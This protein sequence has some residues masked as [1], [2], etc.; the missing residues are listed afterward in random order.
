[1]P[2]TDNCEDEH[3]KSKLLHGV[4]K[5][6][7]KSQFVV[8]NGSSAAHDEVQPLTALSTKEKSRQ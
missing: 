2:L 7:D 5:E 1:M 3:K 8:V 4:D 6:S